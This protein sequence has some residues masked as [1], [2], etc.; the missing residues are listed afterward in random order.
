MLSYLKGQANWADRLAEKNIIE[1]FQR[2]IVIDKLSRQVRNKMIKINVKIKMIQAFMRVCLLKK[3][4]S[5]LEM[6]WKLDVY[7]V[8]VYDIHG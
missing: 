7:I 2:I 3:Y 1:N 5:M 6:Q 4:Q 8:K